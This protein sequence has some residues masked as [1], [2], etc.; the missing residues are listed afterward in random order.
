MMRS[1]VGERGEIY[2]SAK[3]RV[4]H[5]FTNPH[6]T[7][8]ASIFEYRMSQFLKNEGIIFDYLVT[9]KPTQE[10]HR[11]YESQGSNIYILPID[12][13]H[14]L[15]T[16]EF[17]INKEYYRFFKSH[18]YDIVYADTENALR[19]MH[20]LMARLA[21]VKVRVVHSHNTS[22]Q[23]ESKI[24]KSIA[25]FIR[26]MFRV[27]A[28]H[29]FA[30]SELA[31]KWLFPRSVYRN[32]NYQL[33]SNGINLKQFSFNEKKR[34]EIRR[35]LNI[36]DDTLVVGHVGRF[37]PQKNHIF[38][39][40][41]FKE[42]HDKKK[43]SILLLIGDGPLQDSIKDKCS[44]LGL[45]NFVI[46]YGTTPVVENYLQAMDVFLMPSLFEGLPITGIE[47]QA[48]GLPCVF[49]D[50]ITKELGIT[51]LVRYFPLSENTGRWA[52][53]VI[54]TAACGRRDCGQEIENAG[55]SF[56]KTAKFLKKFY[57][58]RGKN[59]D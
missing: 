26:G 44:S 11:R 3:I 7:N 21:G 57:L 56:E 6:L 40:D 52:D 55:Y 1:D 59:H 20:L 29:Y 54:E 18:P 45:D 12:N 58:E 23:T 22:L 4:L 14:G 35:E 41:V 24:S 42:I 32:N 48:N 38:L 53:E 36:S 27:S 51:N 37:M 8:G 5:L 13:D 31:A 49:S 10:E 15:L 34:K 25:R 47:A 30:C 46:F 39:I 9:E 28:T 17:K 2:S 43:D 16:R 19:A 50:T 33:L